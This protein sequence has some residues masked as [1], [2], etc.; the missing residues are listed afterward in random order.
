MGRQRYALG[1]L[2]VG[3]ALLLQCTSDDASSGGGNP[4]GS[5][6]RIR[7]RHVEADGIR[8]QA[9]LYDS[10]LEQTCSFVETGRDEDGPVYH[11]IRA[12]NAEV[13]YAD[14][15]CSGPPILRAVSPE[16]GCGGVEEGTLVYAVQ[17]SSLGCGS[18]YVPLVTGPLLED[19]EGEF[20]ARQFGTG[21][22]APATSPPYRRYFESR[23]PALDDEY[24]RGRIEEVEVEGGG[25]LRYMV[26]S[27][28]SRVL[29][30][31]L[32]WEGGT[33][34]PQGR[35]GGTAYCMPNSTISYQ[36][37]WFSDSDCSTPVVTAST[38]CEGAEPP[39]VAII[40]ESTDVCEPK[41]RFVRVGEPVTKLYDGSG[42]ECVEAETDDLTRYYTYGEEIT[43]PTPSVEEFGEGRL[44]Y[45][46][47]TFGGKLL[48]T[49]GKWFDTE[50][51]VECSWTWVQGSDAPYCL[52]TPIVTL[53]YLFS[54]PDCKNQLPYS[55][56]PACSETP[57]RSYLLQYDYETDPCLPRVTTIEELEPYTGPVYQRI[58]EE[59]CT[60]ADIETGGALVWKTVRELSPDDFVP[61]P[62]VE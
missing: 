35:P 5:G 13:V 9:D 48:P 60:E 1:L 43:P 40:S 52:P 25:S 41:N 53:G 37:T 24:V 27:D 33:C 11:C 12:V 29:Q 26:G 30:S 32:G 28:G 44:R 57:T 31:S 21:E 23:E 39:K 22:C 7:V 59:E 45:S 50:L 49:F 61:R 51:G 14:S 58:G 38:S 20:Y 42:D 18:S 8:L 34:T 46:G 4:D 36:D 19:Q 17:A 10:K 55:N 3:G 16:A 62:P 15:D 6:G 54:D 2:A 47:F 56:P